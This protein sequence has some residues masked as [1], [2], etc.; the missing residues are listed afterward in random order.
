M[1]IKTQTIVS[2]TDLDAAGK[3][4]GFGAAHSFVEFGVEDGKGNRVFDSEIWQR[5]VHGYKG[6]APPAEPIVFSAQTPW[7]PAKAA[8]ILA[9]RRAACF[10][11]D[12]GAG[13]CDW[14]VDGLCQHIGCKTCAGKQRNSGALEAFI[15]QPHSQCPAQKWNFKL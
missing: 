5:I 2:Q 3:T 14:N 13:K 4:W 15:K 6:K 7:N 9:A 11:D 10:G 1:K 8:E 12:A